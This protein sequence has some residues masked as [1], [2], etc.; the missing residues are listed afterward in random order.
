VLRPDAD[1]M[2]GNM[3]ESSVPNTWW[4]KRIDM[5]R[6]V[7][8][9]TTSFTH[10]VAFKHVG[11]FGNIGNWDPGVTTATKVTEGEPGVGTAYDL[12]LS[13]AGRELEMR[14]VIT[15]YDPGRK[16]VLEGTGARVHA[17]DVFEFEDHPGGT[18][19]TYTA[20]LSLTGF[21]RFFEPLMKGRFAKIGE[22]AGVGLRRWLHELEVAA[23]R[24]A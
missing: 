7:E 23:E 13:Y 9:A 14:Y 11:D 1:Q 24:K 5:I 21:A 19:V 15:E 17:I 6:L 3:Q 22:E 2:S 4:Q 20:D 8:T 18:Q 10:E 12:V 16:I